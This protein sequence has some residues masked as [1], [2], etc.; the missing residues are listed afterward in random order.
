MKPNLQSIEEFKAYTNRR[1]FLKR[2]LTSLGAMAFG[3]LLA[4]SAAT[5]GPW[6]GT[7]GVGTHLPPKVKRV[8]HLCMAGGPSHL[9]SFDYKPELARL[10]GQTMTDSFTKG[11]QLAQ[12]QGKALKIMG[13]NFGFSPHGECGMMISDRFPRQARAA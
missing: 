9:E 3:D 8:I 6:K 4:Q 10:H 1:T 12:L 5:E 2:S 7:L 13:P 11:Q